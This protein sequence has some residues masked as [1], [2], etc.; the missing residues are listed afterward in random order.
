M[1]DHSLTFR[2]PKLTPARYELSHLA[3]EK[4]LC[5]LESLMARDRAGTAM[6]LAHIAEV[7]ARRLYAPAGHPS[8]FAYC[9][10]ARHL[11]EDAAYRRIRAARAARQ[12]P[13]LF[14]AIEDGRLHL[15]GTCLL[16]PHLAAENLDEL[17][18]A[19]T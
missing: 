6:L 4:L 10:D 17:I 18:E 8:M 9:V 16:A 12:F 14:T 13:A 1:H 7:D 2:V 3:D 15:A 5:D 19:A 11:S